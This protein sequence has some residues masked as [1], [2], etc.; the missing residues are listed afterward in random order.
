FIGYVDAAMPL[1]EKTGIA[2]SLDGGV[3]ALSGPKDVT[4]FLTA[5]GALR[6]WAREPKV[7]MSKLS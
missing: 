6:L 1:F 3:I 4:G 2:D 7:K 5:L